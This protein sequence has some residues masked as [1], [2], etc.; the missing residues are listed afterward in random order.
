VVKGGWCHNL[1]KRPIKGKLDCIELPLS[2][3]LYHR[4]EYIPE[5][6]DFYIHSLSHTPTHTYTHT[7]L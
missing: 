6:L 1:Q 2:P 3:Q 5:G 4:E 7:I